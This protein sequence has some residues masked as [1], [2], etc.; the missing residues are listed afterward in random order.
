MKY[1]FSILAL[2]A[3]LG[4]TPAVRGE[5]IVASSV[6]WLTVASDV[7]ANGRITSHERV[8]GPYAVVYDTYTL[9]PIELVKGS[10]KSPIVFILR[11]LKIEAAFE[12]G[13]EAIVFLSKSDGNDDA[14]LTGK[15]VPTNMQFPLSV[16]RSNAPEGF[17]ISI[18]QKVLKNRTEI[19]DTARSAKRAEEEYLKTKPRRTIKPHR[20]E[21]PL[22]GEAFAALY[23]GSVTYLIIPSFLVP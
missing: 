17:F 22:H 1:A 13:D 16:T 11:Q 4:L 12:V 23:R 19:L 6:E 15:L 7:I 18:A 21:L 14:F 3:T 8:K 20:L 9:A 5:I 2:F 10:R